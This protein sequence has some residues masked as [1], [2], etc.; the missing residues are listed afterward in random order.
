[1][2]L[3]HGLLGLLRYQSKT[4]YE[5][6]KMFGVSLNSF[7]HAQESQ[8]YRELK[9]LEE[10][11]LVVSEDVIQHGKPNKRV[12]TITEDGRA[13]FFDWAA[14]SFDV[15]KNRHIPLLLHTFFGAAVPDITLRRLRELRQEMPIAMAEQ[16]PQHQA[17]IE[18]LKAA[19]PNGDKEAIF[20]QMTALYGKLEA[21]AI[22]KWTE[23]CINI[24]E[25]LEE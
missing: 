17:A 18:R 7:W 25:N 16:M 12:Y 3:P 21:E 11:G 1:M 24:L 19:T 8:I 5:L 2:S 9:R 6:T 22:I 20:W 14:T 23:E 15:N 10:K 13:E 4:G